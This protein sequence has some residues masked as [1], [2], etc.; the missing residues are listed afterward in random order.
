VREFLCVVLPRMT[1]FSPLGNPS[2]HTP[3]IDRSRLKKRGADRGETE[4][5]IWDAEFR[6]GNLE[7]RKGLIL[8][9]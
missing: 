9:M 4:W 7:E 6:S 2:R 5:R 8:R 3:N 1:S